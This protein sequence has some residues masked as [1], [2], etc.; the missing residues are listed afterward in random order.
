MWP[1]S[2]FG[3][4]FILLT[5]SPFGTPLRFP[6]RYT[7]HQRIVRLYFH[8]ISHII[9]RNRIAFNPR[10]IE[11]RKISKNLR[12]KQI[13]SNTFCF[14]YCNLSKI[15]FHVI[16]LLKTN[17]ITREPDRAIHFLEMMW[18]STVYKVMYQNLK[19]TESV[20]VSKFCTNTR[21]SDFNLCNEIKGAP[22]K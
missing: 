6:V 16:Y 15:V 4:I 19:W 18:Y 21:A 13:M 17:Y 2:Y 9:P 8:Q 14:V 5:F 20:R 3:R 12:Q 11:S 1:D 22:S 7:V 10:V